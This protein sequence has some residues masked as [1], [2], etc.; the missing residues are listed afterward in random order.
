LDGEA[1]SLS[2]LRI[3]HGHIHTLAAPALG[4]LRMAYNGAHTVA[5]LQQ[6]A[7]NVSTHLPGSTHNNI[8]KNFP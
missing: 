7:G 3:G 2:V 1:Q 8:H 5:P 4:T 6:A